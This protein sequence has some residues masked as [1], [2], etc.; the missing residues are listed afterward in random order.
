MV[1]FD[2]VVTWLLEVG[3]AGFV[4]LFDGGC[5]LVVA[6]SFGGWSACAWSIH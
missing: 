3:A 2:C 5:G 4:V 1:V 6:E